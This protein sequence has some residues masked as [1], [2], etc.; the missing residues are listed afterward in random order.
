[1]AI[2]VA[3][4]GA[5]RHYQQPTILYKWG[6]LHALY[7]DFYAG[8]SLPMKA[9]RYPQLNRCL[10]TVMKRMVDRY[11]PSLTGAR[12]VHFPRLGYQYA[13]TLRH[14]TDK[15]AASIFVEVGK[16]FCHSIIQ[17]GLNGADVVYG[18]NSSCLELFEYSKNQGLHCILDQ[19]QA[20]KFYSYQ[21]LQAEEKRW[22]GWSKHSFKLTS[23]EIELSQRQLH[24]Q[25]LAD[26]I[27]CG[28]E[29]VKDSLIRGG[30]AAEKINVVPLGRVKDPLSLNIPEQFDAVQSLHPWT[31][32]SE[33]LRILF[34]G[35]VGLRK[36]VPYLLEALHQI[37]GEIPFF[38]KIAGSVELHPEPLGRYQDVC[39]FLGRVPRSKMISLYRW[40]DVLVLPS[41]CEGSA[42]VT[43]EALQYGLPVIT[44]HHAGSIVRDELG[45]WIVPIR[46]INA[47]AE[48]L[49][50]LFERGQDP[51]FAM[52]L[53]AHQHKIRTKA[54]ADFKN[55][56]QTLS[57]NLEFS[58]D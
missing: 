15:S 12:V 5:R 24:E 38:C 52:R 22:S 45:G 57:P 46:N 36:G 40:A 14:S 10:P 49:L 34:A 30:T 29:F 28:S 6:I 11:T 35:S 53:Q 37:K 54:L 9:L 25:S 48:A 56:I 16:A 17:H 3:Q 21:L 32:R 41:I 44:T 7:T 20:E 23:A 33:G 47:I 50:S 19:T 8:D 31:E 1:M 4:L 18:F 51:N 2:L 42:M 58:D 27:I 43:Y 55:A 26:Q 39:Q 13:R